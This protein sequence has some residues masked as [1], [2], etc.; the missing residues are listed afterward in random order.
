M[1]PAYVCSLSLQSTQD[2][3]ASLMRLCRFFF[4]HALQFLFLACPHQFSL[5]KPGQQLGERMWGTGT[6]AQRQHLKRK[7]TLVYSGHFK[8]PL[9][10]MAKRERYTPPRDHLLQSASILRDH[11]PPSTH[12][13]ELLFV[14]LRKGG[15]VHWALRVTLPPLLLP[16][17]VEAGSFKVTALSSNAGDLSQGEH[18]C[19]QRQ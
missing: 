10:H 15:Q 4:A 11:P 3:R 13:A 7:L 1:G 6:L 2:T 17:W 18:G 19:P 9:L 16:A 8:N 14:G 12:G 5:T